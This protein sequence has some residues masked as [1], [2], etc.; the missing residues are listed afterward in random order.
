M[1]GSRECCPNSTQ[2]VTLPFPAS[3][4][5]QILYCLSIVDVR[6]LGRTPCWRPAGRDRLG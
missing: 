6:V 3:F 5:P 4:A 2:L 1:N